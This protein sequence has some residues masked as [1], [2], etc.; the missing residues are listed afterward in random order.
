MTAKDEA[1]KRAQELLTGD[2]RSLRDGVYND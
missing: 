2:S 1:L